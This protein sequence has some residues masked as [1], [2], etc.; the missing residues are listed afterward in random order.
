LKCQPSH[1]VPYVPT[2]VNNIFRLPIRIVQRSTHRNC[3][4]F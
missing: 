1:F 2:I 4:E 3:V